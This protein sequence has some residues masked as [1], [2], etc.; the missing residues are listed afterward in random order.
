[1]SK[2]AEMVTSMRADFLKKHRGTRGHRISQFVLKQNEQHSSVIT[3]RFLSGLEALFQA[4]FV[5]LAI[6]CN[7]TLGTKCIIEIIQVKGCYIAK[8]DRTTWNLC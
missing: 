3:I 5:Y 4:A 1:M 7:V 2:A 8:R 6:F